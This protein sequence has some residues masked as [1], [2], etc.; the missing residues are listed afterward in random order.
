FILQIVSDCQL[1]SLPATGRGVHGA[2]RR[3]W[4]HV[5]A[6]WTGNDVTIVKERKAQG[7]FFV[8]PGLFFSRMVQ[9]V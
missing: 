1:R 8:L 9:V 2:W 4:Q 5:M 6:V 3:R 7:G